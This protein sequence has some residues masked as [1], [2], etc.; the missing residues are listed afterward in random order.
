MGLSTSGLWYRP[1]SIAITLSVLSS[2][3]SSFP[4]GPISCPPSSPSPPPPAHLSFCHQYS[5]SSCCTPADDRRILRSVA[6]LYAT[7]DEDRFS[8]LCT[9]L[10]ARH[11]CAVCSPLVS[12]PSPSLHTI[13]LST[14]QQWLNACRN[15]MFTSGHS[16]RLSP[17]QPNSL[18]C[19]PLHDIIGDDAADFCGRSGYTVADDQSTKCYNGS[20]PLLTRK[21]PSNKNQFKPV[22]D[23]NNKLIIGLSSFVICTI[24]AMV[25]FWR[26]ER[27]QEHERI[28]EQ[29]RIREKRLAYIAKWAENNNTLPIVDGIDQSNSSSTLDQQPIFDIID[30]QF[31]PLSTL[32]Q[33]DLPN[34]ISSDSDQCS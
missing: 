1:L 16:G 21:L 30:D 4:I 14:C 3:V 17:C 20:I 11:A 24:L 27:N 5:P 7:A 9:T 18:I 2:L 33:R 6:G 22:N 19:S 15:D 26:Y 28:R 10:T 31:N 32:D 34:A 8:N 23:S 13:C 25:L 29:E 12:G